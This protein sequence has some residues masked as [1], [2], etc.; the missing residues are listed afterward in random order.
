MGQTSRD[1]DFGSGLAFTLKNCPYEG[2]RVQL[3]QS[4]KTH[5]SPPPPLLLT[6]EGKRHWPIYS[7]CKIGPF[8]IFPLKDSR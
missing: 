5:M 8:F 6:T 2:F 7:C 1:Y 4:D 3:K